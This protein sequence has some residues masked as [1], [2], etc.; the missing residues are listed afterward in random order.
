MFGAKGRSFWMKNILLTRIVICVVSVL[1]IVTWCLFDI[2]FGESKFTLATQLGSKGLVGLLPVLIFYGTGI[3][4]QRDLK[5]MDWTCLFLLGG[6]AALGSLVKQSNLLSTLASIMNKKLENI[7]A[8]GRFAIVNL[9]VLIVSNFVSHTVAAVTMMPLVRSI[10]D[11]TGLGSSF[12]VTSVLCDSAAC[13][14]PVSSFPNVLAYGLRDR[15]G[16]RIL[17]GM[18]YLIPACLVE[19]A[20][21]VLMLSLGWGLQKM[22]E[23]DMSQMVEL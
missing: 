20:A 15:H 10:G 22:L 19:S 6:G 14:L 16:E 18:D 23:N 13:C 4:K 9:V 5:E 3:L 1:T 8:Y 11:A 12:V 2:P 17:T 7:G 21:F